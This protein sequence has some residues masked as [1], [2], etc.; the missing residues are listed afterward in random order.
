MKG[1]RLEPLLLLLAGWAFYAAVQGDYLL[2]ALASLAALLVRRAPLRSFAPLLVTPFWRNSGLLLGVALGWVW[3]GVILAPPDAVFWSVR[4]GL[5]ATQAGAVLVGC[6]VLSVGHLRYSLLAA[7]VCVALAAT[8][9]GSPLLSWALGGFCLLNLGLVLVR[10]WRS[11]AARSPRAV[12]AV[13]AF[14]CCWVVLSLLA[15][16]VVRVGERA[17]EQAYLDAA[18]PLPARLQG[19]FLHL[20]GPDPA[21][22]ALRPVLEVRTAGTG[23]AYLRTRVFQE[24]LG[25]AWR[26]APTGERRELPE[27]S[28]C[29]REELKLLFLGSF[30]ELLPAPAGVQAASGQA[31]IDE[32]DLVHGEERTLARLYVDPGDGLPAPDPALLSELLQLPESLR[33]LLLATAQEIV[34]GER[35]PERS[36]QAIEAWF[37]SEF[38]YS[39][40]PDL[41][42]GEP[43]LEVF[44]RQRRAAYCV[45][46]ASAAALLL[47]ARGIPARVAGGFLAQEAQGDGGR[48][49]L[50]RMRDAHAWTEAWIE[51]GPEGGQGRWLRVDATPLGAEQL[52]PGW[53]SAAAG[54][55]WRDLRWRWAEAWGGRTLRDLALRA[56]PLV[57]LAGLVLL[58]RG[59]WRRWQGRV[60]RSAL[61][62]GTDL[63]PS[64]LEPLYRRFEEAIVSA[65]GLSRPASETDGELIRRL[66]AALP[67]AALAHAQRFL[68]RYRAAR[69]GQSGEPREALAGILAELEGALAREPPAAC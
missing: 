43:G 42:P 66:E 1:M 16:W 32:E 17:A 38:S 27:P 2:P 18:R 10:Q 14:A 19:A 50:V 33:P 12:A 51:P 29:E 49:K 54:R 56:L 68:R 60:R 31:R 37:H 9:S 36:A 40:T 46:F 26:A 25:G 24:Y 30:P 53:L 61:A 69:F 44:L 23:P 58:L 64:A 47:R 67:S 5:A 45:H 41:P 11:P 21:G 34:G 57:A 52:E 62:A 65:T 28:V 20:G 13:A 48:R 22:T 59:L 15:V 7:W 35:D 6:L 39:L 3:R 8:T 63:A 4:N 55:L